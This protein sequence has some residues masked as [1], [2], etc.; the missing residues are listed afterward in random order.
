MEVLRDVTPESI[1]FDGPLVTQRPPL[2]LFIGR[3]PEFFEPLRD[4]AAG[5]GRQCG[6]TLASIDVIVGLL[7]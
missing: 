1:R 6:Q 7:V 5:R 2:E 4:L 3:T